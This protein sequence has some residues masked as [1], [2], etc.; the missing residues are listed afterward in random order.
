MHIDAAVRMKCY[1]VEDIPGNGHKISDVSLSKNNT[2]QRTFLFAKITFIISKEKLGFF[3]RLR[4][5]NPAP[6]IETCFALCSSAAFDPDAAALMQDPMNRSSG[7][8]VHTNP[9]CKFRC[10]MNCTTR[11]HLL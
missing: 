7:I 1:M 2:G 3:S 8:D 4:I 10:S 9:D 5:S 11:A 6:P